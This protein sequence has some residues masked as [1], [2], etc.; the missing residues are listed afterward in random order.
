[1]FAR[2]YYEFPFSDLASDADAALDRLGNRAPIAVGTNRYQLELG[3][4]EQLFATKRYAQA[5]AA[6]ERLEGA[7]KGD[8]HELISLRLAECAYLQRRVREARDGVKPYIDHARRQ[9]EAL[10]FYAAAL[11]DLDQADAYVAVVRRVVE[12]FPTETWADEALNGL[13]TFYI[14]QGDDDKADATFREM[15]EK[16]PL[17]RNA[18]RA[19]WKIGWQSYRNRQYVD[20]VRAFESAAAAF[21]RSDFRPAWLYWAARAHEALGEQEL[22][23]ARFRLAATDYRNSYYGR[24]AVSRLREA[25]PHARLVA[26]VPSSGT[27]ASPDAA[28][29]LAALPLPSN[30][31]TI[32]AL[33]RLGLYDQAID[34]LRYAQ[35]AWGESPPIQATLAWIYAQQGRAERGERQ[36]TLY[37]TAIN[38]MKRAYPQF[39]ASDGA[40]LPPD[41]MRV[42]FPIGYWD[43]I[44]KHAAGYGLDPYLVAA[45]VAQESTFVPDIVSS[46]R[47]VGLMQLEA[48]TARQYARKLGLRYSPRLLTE[49]ESSIRIGMAKLADDL[50]RFGDLHLVLASYNAG[51]SAV[52]RWMNDRAGLP[53]DEFIDDIPYPETQGYVK[54]ILG[55]AEDYRRLYGPEA[56]AAEAVAVAPA[57]A[58]RTP[59]AARP[60]SAVRRPTPKHRAP[61]RPSA[62]AGR[63]KPAVVRTRPRKAV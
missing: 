18:E 43:L 6:F 30:H 26:D 22:A 10:F 35:K 36:F 20:T 50:S 59:R 25:G 19:A 46:A 33:L 21:P 15:Y 55:T 39:L 2:V 4:A 44:Q 38:T 42:I 1:A 45:L 49:P 13:A 41:L 32:R 29:Q 17:G 11:R 3:R 5:R 9:G 56:A 63:R 53:R 52:R 58:T 54:K 57:A 51:P 60:G 47:A 14:R 24:L 8:D 31:H 28:D 61:R 16:F 23:E 40:S 62:S 48:A 12:E 34:E 27:A 37:R 7:A